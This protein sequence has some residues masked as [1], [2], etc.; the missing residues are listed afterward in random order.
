MTVSAQLADRSWDGGPSGDTGMGWLTHLPADE[1]LWELAPDPDTDPPDDPAL[2]E[3]PADLALALFEAQAAAA[4]K[5]GEMFV[6]GGLSRPG[7]RA[8]R[9]FA[10]GGPAERIGPGAVL[11]GLTGRAWEQHERV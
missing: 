8:G 3:I 6:A 2:S 1:E 10:A 9:G 7:G 5:P 4:P 11:A